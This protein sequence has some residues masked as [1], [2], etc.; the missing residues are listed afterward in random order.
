[1]NWNETEDD[2]VINLT[3]KLVSERNGTQLLRN[4]QTGAFFELLGYPIKSVVQALEIDAKLE[5]FRQG[6]GWKTGWRTIMSLPML[7][8]RIPK[9][10]SNTGRINCPI[11][12][13]ELRNFSGVCC[14]DK[15][16]NYYYTWLDGGV[17]FWRVASVQ[18]LSIEYRRS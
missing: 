6:R 8:H 9:F 12:G 11:S 1:M 3:N 13:K 18:E 2:A 5:K 14:L 16:E 10:E 17:R 7:N 15:A 4:G